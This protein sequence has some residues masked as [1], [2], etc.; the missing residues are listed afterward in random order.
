MVLVEPDVRFRRLA[1]LLGIRT[2][3]RDAEMIVRPPRI[4]G[5]PPDNGHIV[6]SRFQHGPLGNLNM[7]SHLRWGKDLSNARV[8]GEQAA[9]GGGDRQFHKLSIHGIDPQLLRSIS[10]S[11]RPPCTGRPAFSPM[12]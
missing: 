9:D 10:H 8:E 3:M 4:D 11:A 7:L 5:G 12:E 2:V 6:V 1:Q